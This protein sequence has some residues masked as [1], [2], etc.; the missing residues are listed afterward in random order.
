M[1]NVGAFDGHRPPAKELVD[2]CDRV[3]VFRRGAIAGELLRADL[4]E[5]TLLRMA[6]DV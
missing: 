4:S 6:T 1:A 3:L 5:E 2:V